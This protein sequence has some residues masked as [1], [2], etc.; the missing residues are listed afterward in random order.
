MKARRDGEQVVAVHREALEI[1]VILEIDPAGQRG[2]DHAELED[3]GDLVVVAERAFPVPEAGDEGRVRGFDLVAIEHGEII[4]LGAQ[5]LVLRDAVIADQLERACGLRLHGVD[6][7]KV[8]ARGQPGGIG[9]GELPV[10]ALDHRVERDLRH[11]AR[12]MKRGNLAHQAKYR[13][14]QIVGRQAVAL[15]Q[16]R[17]QRTDGSGGFV[18]RVA[19]AALAAWATS[20]SARALVHLRSRRR[21]AVSCA[22]APISAAILAAASMLA[23]TASGSAMA[24]SNISAM[25]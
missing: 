19:H 24:R 21:A 5:R 1:V 3:V 22:L 20:L 8:A 17:A 10:L 25:K 14:H 2:H 15:L 9:E 23:S 4:D 11:A 13:V 7:G 6:R 16:H 18:H 12:G